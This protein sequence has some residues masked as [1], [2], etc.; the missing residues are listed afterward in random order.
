MRYIYILLFCFLCSSPSWSQNKSLY[1][2]K[3]SAANKLLEK[4]DYYGALR[5]FTEAYN[6][7]SSGGNIA[8][9]MGLCLFYIGGKESDA[10]K[11]FEKAVKKVAKVCEINSSSEQA[12]SPLTYYY[13]GLL[14]QKT[15]RFA[16]AVNSLKSLKVMKAPTDKDYPAN[17]DHLIAQCNSGKMFIMAPSNAKIINLGD[18]INC[19]FSDYNPLVLQDESS[20]VFTSRRSGPKNSTALPD[21]E[22]HPYVYISYVKKDTIW[23]AAKMFDANL[24][25]LADNACVSITPDGQQMILFS[26]SEKTGQLYLSRMGDEHWEA[27]QKIGSD[28]NTV[29]NETS[30]CLAPDG[31]SLYFVSDRP[32]G[33]GGK[34]IWRCIKLPNGN[35][36]RALNLGKTVNTMYDEETPFMHADGHTFFFSSQGHNSMGGY[37][38]FFSQVLDS[39]KFSEPFNLGY[40]IN[41]PDDEIHFSLSLDGKNGYFNSDRPGGK[42]K[43]D[44]YKVVMP[45][46]TERPLTVIRGQIV[47]SPGEPLSDDV[48]IIATDS[49][50]QQE[51][52]DFKPIKTSGRFTIIVPP[53]RTYTLSYLDDDTEFY[54]EVINVP[55][56]AGYKEI[57]KALNL[58][59]HS[60]KGSANDST[61][62]PNPH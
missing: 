26:N 39:G 32:G 3:F 47:A 38:I 37:D 12:A 7:D 51:V 1:A 4:K 17:V 58:S 55:P 41:T 35:W 50:T 33:I 60:I 24:N 36:S 20:I 53:G 28:V 10:I 54:K 45:H 34:D 42:G 27:P 5:N 48:H 15:Y 57:H 46:A 13:L 18:S 31:N 16:E 30:A 29:G 40:P 43:Q 23:T 2:D 8:Y 25:T 52:G 59:P 44:I 14:Y 19:G 22:Y 62:H 6:A 61:A 21:G 56:D 49:A 11:Y 9:K